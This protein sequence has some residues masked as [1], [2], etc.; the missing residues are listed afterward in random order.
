MG[1]S[2]YLENQVENHSKIDNYL[3]NQKSKISKSNFSKDWK[4]KRDNMLEIMSQT[5]LLLLLNII[6]KTVGTR[7]KGS[8]NTLNVHGSIYFDT[9]VSIGGSSGLKLLA[10]RL[11][12]HLKERKI[13]P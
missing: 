6:T 13:F 3:H 4:E 1:I 10:P 2:A 7:V 12:S 11:T 5:R 9:V 8:P